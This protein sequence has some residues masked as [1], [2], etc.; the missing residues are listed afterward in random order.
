[1]LI[2]LMQEGG[3]PMWFIVGFGLAGLVAAAL[4]AK[5][6]SS[7]YAALARGLALATLMATLAGTTAALGAVFSALAGE[8]FPDLNILKPDGPQ[9]LMKGLAESMSPGIM[10]FA[11]LALSALFYA[12]GSYRG[13]RD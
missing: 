12:V 9:V 10:G 7:R 13:V 3:F 5:T 1:M 11:L 8:R 6:V 2:K 4:Y